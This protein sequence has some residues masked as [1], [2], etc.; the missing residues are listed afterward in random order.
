MGMGKTAFQEEITLILAKK[1]NMH[2]SSIL[3]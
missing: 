1:E 2:F 3:K